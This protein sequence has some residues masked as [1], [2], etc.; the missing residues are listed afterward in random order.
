MKHNKNGPWYRVV[1]VTAVY[2]NSLAWDFHWHVLKYP[3]KHRQ[4]NY[5]SLILSLSLGEKMWQFW[6]MLKKCLFLIRWFQA[7]HFTAYKTLFR[8]EKEDNAP[9]DIER[10]EGGRWFHNSQRYINR[11]PGK[12]QYTHWSRPL[13]YNVVPTAFNP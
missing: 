7:R 12:V 2:D 5:I 1:V 4:F 11:A 3:I 6:R 13:Q 8:N 10:S 9:P